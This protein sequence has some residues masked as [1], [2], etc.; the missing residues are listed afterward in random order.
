MALTATATTA[1]WKKITAILGLNEP[2]IIASSPIKR[3]IKFFVKDGKKIEEVF[4]PLVA[5]LKKERVKKHRVL[6]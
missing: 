1:T 3:N 2:I 4:S 6:I 5:Q